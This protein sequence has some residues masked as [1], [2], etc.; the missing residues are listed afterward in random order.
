MAV[1]ARRKVGVTP[2]YIVWAQEPAGVSGFQTI[3]LTNTYY[4]DAGEQI[5]FGAA[6]GVDGTATIMAT[7]WLTY[8]VGYKLF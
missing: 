1:I 8:V 4:L 5:E 3:D 2:S 6:E 7:T